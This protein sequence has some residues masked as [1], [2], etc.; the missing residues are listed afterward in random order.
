MV[1]IGFPSKE[2]SA[3]YKCSQQREL[4]PNINQKGPFV[5]RGLPRSGWGIVQLSFSR[6]SKAVVYLN[7]PSV[8]AA[9]RHLPL[10]KGGYEDF[11]SLRRA[12]SLCTRE[13]MKILAAYAAPPPF[14]QGRL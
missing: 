7:N 1:E 6:N 10:H 5:Q 11:S 4:P 13:A 12:T 2:T 8:A 3:K 9:P 14:T